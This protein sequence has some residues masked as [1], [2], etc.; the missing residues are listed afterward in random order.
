MPRQIKGF[1]TCDAFIDNAVNTISSLYELSDIGLTYSTNKQQYYSSEDTSYSLYVF[2]QKELTGL[3]QPQVNTVVNVVKEFVRFANSNHTLVSKYQLIIN[4]TNLFNS[5]YAGVNLA[6]LTFGSYIEHM[7]TVGVDYLT[8]TVMGIECVVWIND[9]SFRAF[10]PEYELSIVTP[11]NGFEANVRSPSEMVTSLAAFDLVQFNTRIEAGKN[12][13][14]TTHVRVLNI[15]YKI[16]NSTILRNCHF[17]FIQYGSQGNFDFV[18]RLKLY[19]Y[20]L[21]LGLTGTEVEA[22][23]P[24]ILEINEFFITPRWDKVALPSRVGAYGIHSQ[25]TKAF[26]EVFDLEKYIKV[27]PNVQYLK[28]NSYNFPYDY[29]NILLTVSNGYY[30][31]QTVKDF[32][33]VYPDLIASTSSEIDYA[34]MSTKSQRFATLLENM[35]YIT[36]VESSNQMFTRMLSNTNFVFSIINRGNVWY[37]ACFFDNHQYYVIPK[38]EYML[39]LN[40]A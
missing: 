14:P 34:R 40:A 15:P 10:Y 26:S 32:T 28:D 1:I 35:L 17:G 7:D 23:F 29:N 6:D 4:Y 37:L 19:D 30:S 11:F 25:I 20:L 12:N 36:D 24:S 2:S 27:Y 5:L 22:L 3:S 21:S 33:V 8:F 38:Y 18:L 31:E 9:P 13:K 39:K 16:P